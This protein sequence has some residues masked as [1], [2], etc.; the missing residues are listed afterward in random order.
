MHQ[1]FKTRSYNQLYID[2]KEH[3]LTK[4]S[5]NNEDKLRD[6]ISWL[7]NCPKKIKTLVPR[8]FDYC[9][10]KENTYVDMEFFPYPNV[11]DII[12]EDQISDT[13]YQALSEKVISTLQSIHSC[14]TSIKYKKS[15]L[16]KIYIQK[17]KDR[18]K[19][20]IKNPA[21]ACY[22]DSFESNGQTVLGLNAFKDEFERFVKTTL[23]ELP[24]WATIHGDYFLGNVIYNETANSTKVVDPRGSFG[25]VGSAGDPRYDWAKLAHSVYFNYDLI[26]TGNYFLHHD[27]MNYQFNYPD[28]WLKFANKLREKMDKVCPYAPQTIDL[29]CSLLFLS[30]I[31]LHNENVNNQK[32]FIITGLK[33]F[34][35]FYFQGE[36]KWH[37]SNV[38]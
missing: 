20:Y 25:I 24:E 37:L 2:P 14:N 36:Q 18:I 22:R 30:M 29:I 5:T 35:Q 16:E 7:V 21:F 38:I 4:R 19:Q 9:L 12:I 33:C 15:Y 13:K 27:G 1:H 3:R 34:T 8:V 23:L 10:D 17:T 26:E 11:A 28:K 31:P 6:E 32:M